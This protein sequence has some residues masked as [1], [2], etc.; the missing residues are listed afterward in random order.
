[1]NVTGW[2]FTPLDFT[3]HCKIEDI[4]VYPGK[5]KRFNIFNPYHVPGLLRKTLEAVEADLL[6]ELRHTIS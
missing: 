3:S 2:D 6:L 5:S 1:M 4:I